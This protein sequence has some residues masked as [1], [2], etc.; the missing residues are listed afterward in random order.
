M[1]RGWR[2]WKADFK[3]SLWML[4]REI[5]VECKMRYFTTHLVEVPE[6]GN[7]KYEVEGGGFSRDSAFRCSKI[8]TYILRVKK[9]KSQSFLPYTVGWN[10]RTSTINIKGKIL[11]PFLRRSIY[12]Q[13]ACKEAQTP[14]VDF[15]F[16][17]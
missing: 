3:K 9:K 10:C 11:K 8:E 15:T 13:I 12:L 7:T 16:W 6:T 2:N 14:P 17:E 1:N 5:Y 4:Y